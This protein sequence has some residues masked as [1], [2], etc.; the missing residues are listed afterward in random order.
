VGGGEP[1]VK[2]E[3]EDEV[4][5]GCGGIEIHTQKKGGT[6]AVKKRKPLVGGGGTTRKKSGRRA[7]EFYNSYA[8]GKVEQKNS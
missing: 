7:F 8:G 3:K 6:N 5:G 2:G 1:N 4:C